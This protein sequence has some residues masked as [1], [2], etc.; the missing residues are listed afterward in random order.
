MARLGRAKTAL[1]EGLRKG[2]LRL[3]EGE[4]G[5]EELLMNL[6]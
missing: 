6:L 5:V 1:L 4:L 3:G 2:E